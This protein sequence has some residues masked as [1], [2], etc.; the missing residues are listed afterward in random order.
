MHDIAKKIIDHKKLVLITFTV[1]VIISIFLS[2]LVN[3]N[4]NLT[5]YLP[6][7]SPSTTALDVMQKEFTKSPPNARIL[8]QNVSVP[9]ALEFKAKFEAVD[10]VDEVNWLDDTEDVLKPLAM[11]DADNLKAWYKDNNALYNVVINVD[12]QKSAVV[13]IQKIVEGKGEITGDV[14]DTVSAQ[15]TTG[16]ETTKM[17]IAVVPIILLILLI[18]TS[19]WFEPVLFMVAILVAILINNGTNAFLGE[20]SFITKTT[21]AILQ[22]AV[23]MDYSIFLLHRFSDFRNEGQDIKTAMISAMK[24][25]F[26][27]ILAS[28]LTTAIGFGALIVMRFKIGPDLGI[29]LAKG[30]LFSMLSIMLLLPVL[31][32]FTYKLI[33]KTHHRSFLPSFKGFAKFAKHLGIPVIILVIILIVPSFLAQHKN[34]FMYGASVMSANPSGDSITNDLFGKSNSMVILVPKGD[35]LKEKELSVELANKPYVTSLI[36]YANTIGRTI[37]PEFLPKENLADLQSEHYSRIVISVNTSQEGKDAFNAVE[38]LRATTKKYYENDSHLVG[39]T[40]SVYDMR[41]TVISDNMLVTIIA[42]VGIGLVL[43]FTFKSLTLP[44]I[45]L[46]TIETSIWIN[47]SFPYFLDTKMA[48]LGFMIISS[49]QLG[50]TVDY[51]ILFTNRYIENRRQMKKKEAAIT[52]ISQTS[53][54]IMTSAGILT[55]AGFIMGIISTNG[56]IGQLGTLI[57]RGTLLSAIMVFFFLPTMLIIFDKVIQK[58]TLKLNFYNEPKPIKEKPIKKHE[59]KVQ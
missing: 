53:A 22:L 26:S 7:G 19:S 18:S 11:M 44:F 37:P 56:V 50:A 20:V 12:K 36:S 35:V 49:I 40:A 4:Y 13:E 51:A 16:S 52:T 55:V 21:S 6:D 14:V 39:S 47:L 46:L 59:R 5:N 57:G 33:D 29:V 41:N 30:I 42:I 23:S 34:D 1:I 15:T 17:L 54:S 58:T 45:L 27:S 2:N 24:K 48:Y 31:T 8:V 28:G 3:V 38:D 9:E 32:V 43:L 10:G 25:S